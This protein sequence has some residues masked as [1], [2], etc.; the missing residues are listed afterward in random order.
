MGLRIIVSQWH[1]DAPARRKMKELYEADSTMV[2][3][4]INNSGGN[5]HVTI[6]PASLEFHFNDYTTLKALP[7]A[8]ILETA[9]SDRDY[10]IKRYGG[11]W[12]VPPRKMRNDGLAF[13]PPGAD[14]SNARAVTMV[15]NDQRIVVPGRYCSADEKAQILEQ[16]QA[17]R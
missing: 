2:T 1:D 5:S 8:Q 13:F 17:G 4:I 9:R 3:V 16:L 15:L 11:E 12:N 10:Y 14:L 7:P 6:D